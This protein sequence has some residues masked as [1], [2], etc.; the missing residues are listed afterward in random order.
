MSSAD[1]AKPRLPDCNHRDLACV[2]RCKIIF[3]QTTGNPHKQ[4]VLGDHT[5]VC[6]YML[7]VRKR[8]VSSAF[9]EDPRGDDAPAPDNDTHGSPPDPAPDTA[10]AAAAPPQTAED[11]LEGQ[12]AK[13]VPR[14]D[15]K[16]EFKVLEARLAILEPLVGIVSELQEKIKVLE[17]QIQSS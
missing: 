9:A 10:A 8:A 15:A 5:F 2:R 3:T 11:H 16:K 7:D 12:P 14:F 13:K 6:R 4:Q 17:A 1:N